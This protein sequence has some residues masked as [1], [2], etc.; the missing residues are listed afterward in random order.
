MTNGRVLVVGGASGIGEAAAMLMRERG[1]RV[2][3]T[4]VDANALI[5]LTASAVD[6][7]GVEMDVTDPDDVGRAISEAVSL[8]GGM[9]SLV[10]CAGISDAAPT[11]DTPPDRWKRLLDVN[12]NGG[13]YTIREALPALH[14]SSRASVVMTS[15]IAAQLGLPRRASYCASK[16]AVEALVRSLAV[17]FAPQVRF[18]AVAP[19]YVS[20]RLV[21]QAIEQGR[22][23]AQQIIGSIPLQR[24]AT[25]R[26]IA[27]C[28]AFLASESSGFVTGQVLVADGGMTVNATW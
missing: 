18:N 2:C 24:M 9:D 15:S 10:V 11:S 26:E 6:I 19:G 16:G 1:W 13:Y 25:P 20:T 8:L 27:E 4:D 5:R 23:E 3:V 14:Q 7:V 28:I 22:V 21:A 17:E 12:L